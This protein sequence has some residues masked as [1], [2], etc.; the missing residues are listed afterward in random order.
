[1]KKSQLHPGKYWTYKPI[2][3]LINSEGTISIFIKKE[4][5]IF[6]KFMVLVYWW[7]ILMLGN[8]RGF[9]WGFFVR[10]VWLLLPEP[11]RNSSYKYESPTTRHFTHYQYDVSPLFSN[12]PRK[13]G[14][15]ETRTS[16]LRWFPPAIFQR[17]NPTV[18]MS[19]TSHSTFFGKVLTA[20]QDRAGFDTKYFA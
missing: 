7:R 13:G 5:I 20:T 19:S 12:V 16:Q 4:I 3:F 14:Q 9:I 1:M 11:N 6:H 8:P 15:G 10:F 17:I 2:I 18:A